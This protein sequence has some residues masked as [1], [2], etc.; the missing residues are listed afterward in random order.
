MAGS[1]THSS[2]LS[3]QTAIS[4]TESQWLHKVAVWCK[5]EF[6][7]ETRV[8]FWHP[9]LRAIRSRVRKEW[10]QTT[11]ILCMCILGVLSLFWGSLYTVRNH[12]HTLDV[13][14]VDFDGR[15]APAVNETSSQIV[16]S[17]IIETARAREASPQPHIS[18]HIKLAADFDYDPMKVREAIYNN[19]AFSAIIVN[20]NAS[21]LLRQAVTRGDALYDPKH[22]CQT[23]YVEARDQ[24]AINSYI[25][26]ELNAFQHRVSSAFADGWIPEVLGLIANGTTLTTLPPQTLSPAIG[27]TTINLRPFGPSQVLPAVTVGLIYLII[28]AFF[29]YTFFLPTHTL[30]TAQCSPGSDT[31]HRKLYFGQLVFWKYMSTFIAYAFMSLSYSFVSLAFQIPFSGQSYSHVDPPPAGMSVNGYGHASFVV[32]WAINYLGMCALGFAC[33]NVAMVVGQ[34]FTAIWLIFWVISNVCTAFYPLELAAGVYGYGLFFP[35][36]NVVKATRVVLFDL[37][38]EHM[39]RHI[40]I[41]VAWWVVNTSVFPLA[42]R[43]FRWKTCQRLAEGA[44]KAQER[45]LENQT[46]DLEKAASASSDGR[47]SDVRPEAR[48]DLG[49]LRTSESERS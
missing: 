42:A 25:I 40:G 19:K 7:G 6:D 43:V 21:S 29:S 23:I 28:I 18:Y 22:A 48:A 37:T 49:S 31:Y 45:R 32:Y 41:L 4:D 10:T 47:G 38:P 35:L 30:F 39:G 2:P 20:P 15:V 44:R 33:E 11:L 34:P 5:G 27:F 12:L 1:S 13:W 9:E 26:P 14:I 16:G 3:G 46:L 36:Y 24:V 17:T 8:G